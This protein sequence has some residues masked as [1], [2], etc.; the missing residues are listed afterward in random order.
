MQSG[1]TS[2]LSIGWGLQG[3]SICF[4]ADASNA[5][6][7]RVA[8]QLNESSAELS[9]EDKEE[10]RKFNH[11]VTDIYCLSLLGMGFRGV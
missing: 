10:R 3:I 8:S 6:V 2:Y 11:F 7:L 4:E 1:K 9:L 5:L